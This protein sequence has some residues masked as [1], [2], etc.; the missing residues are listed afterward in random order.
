MHIC[1]V[2]CKPS[3]L[4][5]FIKLRSL[6]TKIPC[7][8]AVKWR[9]SF[10]WIIQRSNVNI[11]YTTRYVTFLSDIYFIWKTSRKNRTNLPSP[12]WKFFSKFKKIIC[13]FYTE[14]RSRIMLAY[15]IFLALWHLLRKCV[16]KFI[17]CYTMR[18][19][20]SWTCYIKDSYLV[21]IACV[22]EN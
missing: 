8:W 7:P 5:I 17:I 13:Y 10:N 11:R 14:K 1:I 15:S 9:N 12:I 20:K 6:P 18:R 3:W 19:E 16:C 4:T 22:K 21:T 2:I